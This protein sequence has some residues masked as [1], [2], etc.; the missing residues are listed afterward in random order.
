[1]TS[2]QCL[3]QSDNMDIWFNICNICSISLNDS[4]LPVLALFNDG[5]ISLKFKKGGVPNLTESSNAW[6]VLSNS[7][8][9]VEKSEQ[10]SIS[11]AI[12][13]DFSLEHSFESF[14]SILFNSKVE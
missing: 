8:W 11:R 6:E 3:Y 13:L 14:S 7:S 4:I 9:T 5:Q 10:G 1:M 2:S 12:C